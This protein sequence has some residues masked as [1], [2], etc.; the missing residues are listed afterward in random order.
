MIK[1]YE[2][3]S[4]Q[5]E[6]GMETREGEKEKTRNALG[7][8]LFVSHTFFV[9]RTKDKERI[10]ERK[11]GIAAGSENRSSRKRPDDK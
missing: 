8:F 3:K 10:K 6:R 11:E 9:L 2:D 7:K 1:I 4:I 5:T